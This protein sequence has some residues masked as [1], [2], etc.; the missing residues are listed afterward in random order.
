M[1]VLSCPLCRGDVPANSGCRTCHLSQ[2][3]VARHQPA[4]R[5][6]QWGR[7]LGGRCSG[8]ALYLAAVAWTAVQMPDA[9]VF[10]VPAAVLGGG[11]LHVWKGRPWLGLMVFVLVVVALPVLLWP[12]LGTGAWTNFSRM[13]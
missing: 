10:V 11:L 4:P 6:K 13:W 9:V 3:D 5:G 12:A 8:V 7:A 2:A 1:Q